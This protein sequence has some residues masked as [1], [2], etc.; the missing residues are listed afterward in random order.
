MLARLYVQKDEIITLSLTLYKNELQWKDI[1]KT[2]QDIIRI[3]IDFSNSTLVSQE[4]TSTTDPWNIVKLKGVVCRA[5]E[6]VETMKRQLQDGRLHL[7]GLWFR[8][9]IDKKSLHNNKSNNP[10]NQQVDE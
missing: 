6:T 3:G 8:I 4:I 10:I 5:K 2:P 7:T 1:D 9:S